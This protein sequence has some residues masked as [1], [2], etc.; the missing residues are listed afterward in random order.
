[1]AKTKKPSKP[2]AKDASSVSNND[3]STASG[4]RPARGGRAVSD[5]SRG[6]GRA[7]DRGGRGGRP[8]ASQTA[9]NGTARNK[10][11]Q[12][13]LS[14]PTEE[15]HAWGD[16]K[17]A[18]GAG[19]DAAVSQLTAEPSQQAA[20]QTKTWA[21]MLRQSTVPKPAPV[22]KTQEAAAT[23]PI[24]PTETTPALEPT[25]AEPEPS[26]QAAAPE[27]ESTPVAEPAVPVAPATA[28][29]EPE[30]ALS[31]SH[32]ELTKTNLEQVVDDSKPPATHTAA[33]T[34]AD[35]WDPRQSN[36]ATPLSAAHQQHQP[37]RQTSS[38][39]AASA[40]KATTERAARTPTYQRRVLDQEE[41]VR[42]PGNREV[43]R[44]AVQF[45]AFNLSGGDEDIDGER[46][47]PETRGQPPA[48]SPSSQPR[49]SLPPT[50]QPGAI[51]ESLQQKQGIPG[52]VGKSASELGRLAVLSLPFY[53]LSTPSSW[54]NSW[55]DERYVIIFQ[56][57]TMF[58]FFC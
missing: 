18:K 7:T 44:T 24:E 46:E 25:P 27:E 54:T 5:G 41:A 11:N 3:S 21:S 36:T 43:D 15:S 29:V 14:V 37:P 47:D 17:V 9:A 19:E 48:D 42:M 56:I 32:D 20:P 22:P 57:E 50:A 2:K 4:A 52:G 34:A 16:D 10:E 28:V 8:R 12:A 49:A 26:A 6:R 55:T 40:L 1:M 39:Y 53:L 13:P 35:S 58:S 33:S 23:A 51:A 30:V 45:G 31:P 38:G